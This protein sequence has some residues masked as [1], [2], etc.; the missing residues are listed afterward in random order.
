MRDFRFAEPVWVIGYQSSI[1]DPEGK[2]SRQNYLCHTF[3][4]DQKVVQRQDQ[5][6][7]AMYSDGFTQEVRLP[8]GFGLPLTPHDN[9]HWMPM[10][11]N[12]DDRPAKVEMR[13]E[14]TLIRQ[15]DLARPLRR[16][17][18]TLRSVQVPHLFYIPPRRHR[19]ETVFTFPFN[20][21]IHFMGT[22][23][24]PYGESIELFNISRQERVWTSSMK[25]DAMGRPVAM[26]TYSSAQG[27]PVKAGENY[28]LT[29]VYNNSTSEPI[30]AMAAIF[31]F[32]SLN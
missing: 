14:V 13:I 9:L 3:F 29:S 30:D 25:Q 32:F 6:M 20:G 16:V 5:R 28:R 26:E 2:R 18:S 24:H 27:Y 17:Y 15:K 12:R 22:H 1:Y 23:I 21:R 10:F 19:R 8:D 4:G 31:L 11:N 7:R